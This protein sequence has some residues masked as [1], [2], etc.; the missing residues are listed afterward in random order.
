MHFTRVSASIILSAKLFKENI[1]TLDMMPN[2]ALHKT[3]N[4]IGSC[5]PSFD[6]KEY[7]LSVTVVQNNMGLFL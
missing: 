7:S 5:E 3:T 2:K 1:L 6:R 4:L